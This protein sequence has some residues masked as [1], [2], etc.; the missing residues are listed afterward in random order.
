M[1]SEQNIGMSCRPVAGAGVEGVWIS[2]ATFN[3]V[4][5]FII[6]VSKMYDSRWAPS[7]EDPCKGR[8]FRV[9]GDMRSEA[10]DRATK[11]SVRAQNNVGGRHKGQQWK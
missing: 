8:L 2:E 11:V 4:S 7:K 1:Q 5:V 9:I 3:Q 6:H 10:I